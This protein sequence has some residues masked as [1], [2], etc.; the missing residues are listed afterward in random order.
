MQAGTRLTYPRGIEGWVDLSDWLYRDSQFSCSQTV[1]Y[2]SSNGA[3]RRVTTTHS[4][5]SITNLCNLTAVMHLSGLA[6]LIVCSDVYVLLCSVVCIEWIVLNVPCCVGWVDP[7]H[8]CINIVIYTHA[9][10]VILTIHQ[11][12]FSTTD[13]GLA[14]IPIFCGH[15]QCSRIRILRFFQISKKH[16]FLRFFEMT[17]QKT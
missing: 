13:C 3:R 1:T 5:T 17:C 14:L 10:C 6:K 11:V 12:T 16:D 2:P 9:H 15:N 8:W 7:V 4:A